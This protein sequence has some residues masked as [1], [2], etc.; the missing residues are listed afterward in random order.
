MKSPRHSDTE[1]RRLLGFLL[2][3]VCTRWGFCSRLTAN[4]LL[5]GR[6]ALSAREFATAVLQAE[7]MS[8]ELEPAWRHS[9]KGCSSIASASDFGLASPQVM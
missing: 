6:E 9:S 3:D 8:V 5:C 1:R 4:G 2:K 7:A